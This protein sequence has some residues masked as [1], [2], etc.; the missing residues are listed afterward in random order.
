MWNPG[1]ERGEASFERWRGDCKGGERGRRRGIHG[2]RELD[3]EGGVEAQRPGRA[4]KEY[5]MRWE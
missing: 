1:R 5:R 3:I 2:V 4:E